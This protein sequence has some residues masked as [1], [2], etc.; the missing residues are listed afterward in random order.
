MSISPDEAAALMDEDSPFCSMVISPDADA[1]F[2]VSAAISSKNISPD[3]LLQ[4]S[5]SSSISLGIFI[6]SFFSD[7]LKKKGSPDLQN[8]MRSTFPSRYGP[9]A[10]S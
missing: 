7:I 2:I 8:C 4:L 3:A 10:L 5:S 1:Q 6:S 9:P